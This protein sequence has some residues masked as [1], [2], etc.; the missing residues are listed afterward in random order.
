MCKPKQHCVQDNKVDLILHSQRQ[1]QMDSR[2]DKEAWPAAQRNL[3]KD[4][5]EGDEELG[6]LC[7]TI[8]KD[9]Q[10]CHSLVKTLC[11]T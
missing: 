10:Q 6:L 4:W 8:P 7:K 5:G 1:P 3:A 11:F 9:W 2:W